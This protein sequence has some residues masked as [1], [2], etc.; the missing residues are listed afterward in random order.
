MNDK[1]YFYSYFYFTNLT[2]AFDNINMK[3]VLL[4]L[5]LIAAVSSHTL[6]SEFNQPHNTNCYTQGLFFLNETHLF[7]S[8][9]L[10][11]RSYFHL[12]EYEASPF[13]ITNSYSSPIPWKLDI[14]L[15]GAVL[16][17]GYIYLLTWRE[18]IVYKLD[19]HNFTL[20]E[21]LSWR[22]QGWGLAENDTHMFVTDGSDKIYL[23]NEQFQL[24]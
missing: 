12:M 5:I 9:G 4:A 22:K 1:L 8:C 18:F 11:N 6:T 10:Y 20:V 15:E 14:F 7:E 23:V 17:K 16:F 3:P 21:Q 13:T 19:P 24:L 2:S